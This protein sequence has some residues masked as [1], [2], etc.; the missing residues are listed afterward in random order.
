[1]VVV[2]D[3][4]S[5][6]ARDR[7]EGA[8]FLTCFAGRWPNGKAPDSYSGDSGF[9]SQATHYLKGLK[10]CWKCPGLLP[11]PVGFD[12]PQAHHGIKSRGVTPGLGPGSAGFDSPDPDHSIHAAA[13]AAVGVSRRTVPPLETRLVLLQALSPPSRRRRVPMLAVMTD[14]QGLKVLVQAH[15]CP[16]DAEYASGKAVGLITPRSTTF[17]GSIPVSAPTLPR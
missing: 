17:A 9:D 10:H 4:S 12:P 5:A 11:R 7:E 6:A 8:P 13:G 2:E 1:M 14:C 3:A 15:E 16:I